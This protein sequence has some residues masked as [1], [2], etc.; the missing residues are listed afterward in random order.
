MA[1]I[2]RDD[3]KNYYRCHSVTA[4]KPFIHAVWRHLVDTGLTKNEQNL[5]ILHATK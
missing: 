2:L 4:V 3:V 5:A 1:C